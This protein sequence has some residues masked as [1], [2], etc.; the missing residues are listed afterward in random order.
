M[1]TL[2]DSDVARAERGRLEERVIAARERLVSIA[3]EYPFEPHFFRHPAAGDGAM[4]HF[5]DEGPRDAPVL[6][7]LHGNP[8][9]SFLWR[10][11]I[12]ALSERFRCVALDHIGCGLSDKPEDFPYLLARHAENVERIALALDLTDITLVAHDWGG[13]IGM[14]F[15]RRQPDRIA[16][17]VLSNTAAFRSKSMP[18]RIAACRVPLF[19]R[20]AVRGMNAFARAATFMAVERPLP[21]AV[22]RGFLLPYDS[23]ANRI[24]THAFVEDIPMRASHPSWDELVHIESSLAQFR[25][26]PTA[27]LWGERDWCFTPAYREAWSAH[28]PQA[29]E[30]RFETAGHYVTEDAGDDYVAALTDFL[31]RHGGDVRP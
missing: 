7:F 9:W 21:P 11:S 25:D 2:A 17:L 10:R 29:E 22:K 28:L 5:I 23:W 31:A 13:A 12:R 27:L 4:Q 15:A 14:G 19:G 8:T 18:L 30:R 20:L 16:R 26:R 1:T 24:A 3:G 6:L